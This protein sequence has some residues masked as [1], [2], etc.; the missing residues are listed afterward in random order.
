MLLCSLTHQALGWFGKDVP[1]AEV[2][3]FRLQSLQGLEI[4]V[5]PVART[6]TDCDAKPLRTSAAIQPTASRPSEAETRA[7]P[8]SY[9]GFQWMGSC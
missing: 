9:S 5:P 6:E 2:L 3:G 7:N 1:L 4:I 8:A